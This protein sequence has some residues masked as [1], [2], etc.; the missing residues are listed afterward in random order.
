MKDNT[1]TSA[2]EFNGLKKGLL[3][4]AVLKVVAAH[5]VYAANILERLAS[6]ELRTSEGTLYPLLSRMRRDKLLEY[7]W[8]ESENGPPR[9]YYYLADAGQAQL[10]AF[11]QYWQQLHKTMNTLGVNHE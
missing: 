3:S 7:E 1:D 9:K 4:F 2:N 10:D 8:V 6:T 5:K 11:E